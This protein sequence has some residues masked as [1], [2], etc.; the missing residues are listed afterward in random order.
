MIGRMQIQKAILVVT[1]LRVGNVQ[2]TIPMGSMIVAQIM[3]LVDG[4]AKQLPLQVCKMVFSCLALKQE[5]LVHQ[6]REIRV[7]YHTKV[8]QDRDQQVKMRLLAYVPQ[9]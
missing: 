1:M 3:C 4:V 6:Y 2:Q 5:H 8:Q 9:S 7:S